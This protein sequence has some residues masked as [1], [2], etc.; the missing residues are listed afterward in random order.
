VNATA[1]TSQMLGT[2]ANDRPPI[3]SLISRDTGEQRFWLGDHADRRMCHE[4][5]MEN[6]PIGST[7]LYPDA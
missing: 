7:Q 5:I 3:I 1:P 6:L 4:R 2:A